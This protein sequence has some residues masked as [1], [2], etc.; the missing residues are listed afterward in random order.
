M[1]SRRFQ[2]SYIYQNGQLQHGEL[3]VE[4]GR[5]VASSDAPA[6]DLGDVLIL[7]GLVNAHSHAFQRLIRGRTE[8][9]DRARLDDDFWTWRDQMYAAALTLD[10]EA[11][12]AASRAAF[13]EM[14]ETGITSVGEFHY[15]HHQP[16]GTRYDDPNELAHRVIAAARDVGLRICLL[17]VAYHRGGHNRPATQGQRRFIEPTVDQYLSRVDA[18]RT[19]YAGDPYVTI[20]V[21]PHSIRAVPGEW[22]TQISKYAGEHNVPFHIHAC[23]QRREIEESLEEYGVEPLI[24]FQDLGVFE[25]AKTVTL[26]HAT[27][28][29]T[30]ELDVAEA[31]KPYVCAC[32]TTERNLGD[33]FLPASE[34]WTRQIPV[35]LGSDSHTNID[36][37]EEMRVIEYHERLRH[38]ARN[39]L[40]TI[41]AR[42]LGVERRDVWESLMPT[43]AEYGARCLHLH[44]G[45]LDV[46]EC[47]DFVVIDLNHRTLRGA[48]ADSVLNDVVLSMTPDAV[49]ATYVAGERLGD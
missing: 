9:V 44:A 17:L 34:L 15:I 43:S 45:T 18:L 2:A 16:D 10:P 6:V 12:Y 28:L 31:H 47:A 29:T 13:L 40:P 48:D 24:A 33:G 46:G 22:L 36:L 25:Q 41:E 19:H 14:A 37:W 26:V 49:S 30:D 23:E 8:Y 38:E 11:I 5:V 20:G 27:H 35:S 1:I 21:A 39:A 4:K 32:P 7:P 42:R 3:C